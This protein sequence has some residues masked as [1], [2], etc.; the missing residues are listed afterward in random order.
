MGSDYKDKLAIHIEKNI[1]PYTE[2]E[3]FVNKMGKMYDEID[4]ALL[5]KLSK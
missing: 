1:C 2:F 5:E 3:E 4:V